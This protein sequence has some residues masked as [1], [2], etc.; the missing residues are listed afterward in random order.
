MKDERSC[1]DNIGLLKEKIFD[2]L[3]SLNG[4]AAPAVPHAVHALYLI[5]QIKHQIKESY[6]YYEKPAPKKVRPD[7]KTGRKRGRPKKTNL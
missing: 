5:T 4:N 7:R 1:E 2:I 6:Y 3:K